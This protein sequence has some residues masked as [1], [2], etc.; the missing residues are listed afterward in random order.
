MLTR[1]DKESATKLGTV[2][3][4]LLRLLID[5]Q[6]R[7]GTSLAMAVSPYIRPEIAMRR[8]AACYKSKDIDQGMVCVVL[9]RLHVWEQHGKVESRLGN[10]HM[11]WR[12]KDKG[13][14]NLVL[15]KR[16]VGMASGTT[17]ALDATAKLAKKTTVRAL[18]ATAKPTTKP[19]FL[20]EARVR[21]IVREEISKLKVVIVVDE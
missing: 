3:V 2:G 13:Y 5:G 6:W 7:S 11:E 17:M 18:D 15:A 12:L 1:R 21:E 10:H 20:T 4:E 9:E 8:A 16:T 19:S 14:A